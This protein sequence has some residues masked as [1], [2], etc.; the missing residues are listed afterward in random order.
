MR[1]FFRNRAVV[2]ESLKKDRKR[3]PNIQGGLAFLG[4]GEKEEKEKKKEKKIE[5]W[6]IFITLCTRQFGPKQLPHRA[7][8]LIACSASCLRMLGY[9]ARR[10]SNDNV[11]ST[12]R[13]IIEPSSAT[14]YDNILFSTFSPLPASR[15]VGWRD[16]AAFCCARGATTLGSA[17]A[18]LRATRFMLM[19][20]ALK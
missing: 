17:F 2:S 3:A 18:A 1:R 16:F 15:S 13:S 14:S 20:A 4:K 7:S 11:R 6:I 12:V 5:D 9:R 19:A 8:L 10:S